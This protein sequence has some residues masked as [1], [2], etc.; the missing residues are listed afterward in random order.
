[1]GIT[2]GCEV[3]PGAGEEAAEQAGALLH[4]LEPGLDQRGELGT[5]RPARPAAPARVRRGFRNIV[6]PS[7]ARP[8]E[9]RP[10]SSGISGPLLATPA[11][12][13]SKPG[14]HDHGRVL[15]EDGTT[16]RKIARDLPFEGTGKSA[17][18]NMHR[19]TI[20]SWARRLMIITVTCVAHWQIALPT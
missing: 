5:P 3:E 9:G 1:M 18:L 10:K 11:R 15:R 20:V 17:G 4:L 6:R 12:Q 2:E 7:P 19:T 16:D 13:G 8:A 14:G